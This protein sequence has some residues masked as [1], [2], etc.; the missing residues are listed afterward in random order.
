MFDA[1]NLGDGAIEWLGVKYRTILRPGESGGS[2]SIVDSLSPAGSGPPRHIHHGEDETF[3]VLSGRCEFWLAGKSFTC[4]PGETAFVPR[5]TE[6]TFR[7][8]GTEPCR[9]L[10]ILTP[11]GFE[12][13]FAEMAAGQF[14]IPEDMDKIAESATRHRMTFTGPPL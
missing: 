3:V 9:H 14:R 7:V 4:G 6:H 13:F 5:G 10:V 8:P 11:G 12:G 2:M 1:M